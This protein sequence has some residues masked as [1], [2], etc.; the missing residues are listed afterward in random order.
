MAFFSALTIHV[1]AD[2]YPSPTQEFFI[3][4]FADVL[5]YETEE[6]IYRLGKQLE[7]KTGAQVV[8]VTIDSLN[9][10]DIDEYANKLFEKWGIGQ[11]DV[12]NGILI[13]FA[14][15]E[16]LLRIEVGYGLEGAVPD[17]K[18][19]EIRENYIRPYTQYDDFDSGFYYGYAAVVNE[20][21]KEYNVEINADTS[22]SPGDLN[23]DQ[24]NG[25]NRNRSDDSSGLGFFAFIVFFLVF[26]GIFLKFRVTSFILK[27]LFWNSFFGGGRRG[28]RGGWGGGGWGGGGF[29]GGGF[30]G[31][32]FGGGGFGG[33]SSGG[34]GR[35][36]G[37]G[38]SGK[39]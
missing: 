25:G 4:D 3:N 1:S 35:S 34:G 10:E 28:G 6:K 17:I 11:K 16:R 20:V 26:D 7:D 29:G 38:S 33:G 36:G 8:L 19:A 39:V 13:L 5:N 18:T 9:G 30:G 23:Q 2:N 21:A 32:G 14:K 31:G 15:A 37:G 27:V 24:H 22:P 12:D